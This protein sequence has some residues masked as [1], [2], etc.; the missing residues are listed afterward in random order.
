[1]LIKKK[2][3]YLHHKTNI[4]NY[5]TFISDDIIKNCLKIDFLTPNAFIDISHKICDKNNLKNPVRNA[6]ITD[7]RKYLKYNHPCYTQ[8]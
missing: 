1:L 6:T 7:A 4:M 2:V 8:V 5:N 3:I